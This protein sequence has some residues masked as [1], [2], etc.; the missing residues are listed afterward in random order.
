MCV[1]RRACVQPVVD[2]ESV[3]K[4]RGYDAT[5]VR[6]KDSWLRQRE[7]WLSLTCGRGLQ[8]QNYRCRQYYDRYDTI[9]DAIL[10]CGITDGNNMVCAVRKRINRSLTC[11]RGLQLQNYRRRQYYDRY[12][13]IRQGLYPPLPSP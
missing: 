12:D 13:T 10:T 9:Q 6:V 2:R 3:R 8:L 5:I 4:I 11:G 1:R 7:P